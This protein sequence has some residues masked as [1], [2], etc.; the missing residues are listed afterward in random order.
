VDV[1]FEAEIAPAGVDGVDHAD[2]HARVGFLRQLA[3]GPSTALRAG[4]GC[5]L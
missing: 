5:G 2:A 1:G 3:D 4:L